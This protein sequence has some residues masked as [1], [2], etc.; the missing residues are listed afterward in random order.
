MSSFAIKDERKFQ[1][2]TIILLL[3]E[4]YQSPRRLSFHQNSNHEVPEESKIMSNQLGIEMFLGSTPRY[5]LLVSNFSSSIQY[6]KIFRV[7][8]DLHHFDG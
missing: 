4:N 3:S 8:I 7:L 2:T 6:P 1:L 5:L